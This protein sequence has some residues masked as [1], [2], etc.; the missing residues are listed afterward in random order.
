MST[1]M[2]FQALSSKVEEDYFADNMSGFIALAPCL[3]GNRNFWRDYD[4]F[5]SNDWPALD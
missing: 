1:T 2:M 3:V 4:K 5:K